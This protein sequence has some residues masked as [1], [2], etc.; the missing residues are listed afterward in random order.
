MSHTLA[1]ARDAVRRLLDD[2]GTNQRYSTASID[3]SLQDAI[4]SC[5]SDY[6]S[7]GGDA[8]DVEVSVV[9]VGGLAT[10]TGPLLCVHGVQ[11][12]SGNT[13]QNV[14]ALQ[15][16]DRTLVD[17]SVRT[18]LVECVKDFVLPTNTAHPFIGDGATDGNSWHAFDLWCFAHAALAL[19]ITDNDRRPGLVSLEERQRRTALRHKNTPSSRPLPDCDYPTWFPSLG[20]VYSA[21]PTAP[22]LQLCSRDGAWQ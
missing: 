17:S 18:L 21:S 11:I 5:V 13:R 20:Y 3:Q 14:V 22:T 6:V 12:S 10:L 4:S 9:T 7:E 8:F 15:R 2:N 19:G 1:N 16:S